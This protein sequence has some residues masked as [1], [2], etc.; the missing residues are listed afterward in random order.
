MK[1]GEWDIEP[2]RLNVTSH[3]I[4]TQT[5]NSKT[6]EIK[7]KSNWNFFFSFRS[8]FKMCLVFFSLSAWYRCVISFFLHF[9]QFNRIICLFRSV[10]LSIRLSIC[11]YPCR[12]SYVS[13]L[14]LALDIIISMY[15]W[16]FVRSLYCMRTAS[17]I[18][19]H[20]LTDIKMATAATLVHYK[21]LTFRI[22]S[23]PF[24][25]RIYMCFHL[26]SQLRLVEIIP[27][28]FLLSIFL[29]T[30]NR[31]TLFHPL[32]AI[33]LSCLMWSSK[34]LFT[35]FAILLYRHNST[36]KVFISVSEIESSVSNQQYDT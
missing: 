13:M 10:C 23:I 8:V 5:L 33:N 31:I 3:F 26:S 25:L 1:S 21:G 11:A 29:L 12:C 14:R 17:V 22:R 36:L 35:E 15:A 4:H 7:Q 19:Q 6:T 30:F 2:P 24:T 16:Q 34:I 9:F 20:T 32:K 28:P 18:T 27:L